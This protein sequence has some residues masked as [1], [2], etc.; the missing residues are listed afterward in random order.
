MS[1]DKTQHVRSLQLGQPQV[2]LW[3]PSFIY[4][5]VWQLQVFVAAREIFELHRGT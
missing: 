1:A 5:Y 3:S 4:L 2:P